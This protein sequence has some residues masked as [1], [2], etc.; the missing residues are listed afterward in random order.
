MNRILRPAMMAIAAPIEERQKT[1]E[2]CL[3][4]LAHIM[5]RFVESLVIKRMD[6]EREAKSK[7]K[8]ILQ[9]SKCQRSSCMLL[10]SWVGLVCLFFIYLHFFDKAH[11]NAAQPETDN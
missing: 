1:C 11:F 8:P 9:V 4:Q 5:S 7:K 2:E 10:Y 3:R 6:T